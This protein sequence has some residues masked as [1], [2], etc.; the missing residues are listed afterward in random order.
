MAFF[1]H[2][3]PVLFG[4]AA[5]CAATLAAQRYLAEQDHEHIVGPDAFEDAAEPEYVAPDFADAPEEEP[6]PA[7]VE[8]AA[9]PQPDAPAAEEKPV[10]TIYRPVPPEA[11]SPNPNPVQAKPA[12]APVVDGK[13][14]A[15]HIADPD[16]FA[17]WDETGCKG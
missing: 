15:E 14:D 4:A 12:K 9:A 10:G 16:D 11:E 5:G 8:A 1:R 17:D 3:L 6:A 7:P 13:V 2:L